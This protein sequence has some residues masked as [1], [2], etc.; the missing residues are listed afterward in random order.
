MNDERAR[1][2]VEAGQLYDDSQ[3]DTLGSMIRTFYCRSMLPLAALVWFWAVVFLAGAVYCGVVFFRT[4]ETRLQILY[5][6][7]FVCCIQ[8]VAMMKVFAWGM[9]NRV[10]I[11]RAIR[12]VEVGLAEM[13]EALPRTA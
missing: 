1:H 4:D 10:R 12:R 2:M 8:F 3:E 7:V 6:A 5:A 11:T 9:I 13:R